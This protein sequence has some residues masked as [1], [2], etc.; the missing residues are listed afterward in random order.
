MFVQMKNLKSLVEDPIGGHF[1]SQI[2]QEVNERCAEKGEENDREDGLRFKEMVSLG[3]RQKI[4]KKKCVKTSI[5]TLVSFGKK[6]IYNIKGSSADKRSLNWRKATFVEGYQ[7]CN[8]CYIEKADPRCGHSKHLKGN[9]VGGHVWNPTLKKKDRSLYYYILPICRRHNQRSTYDEPKGKSDWMQTTSDAK[10]MRIRSSSKVPKWKGSKLNTFQSLAMFEETDGDAGECHE[11]TQPEQLTKWLLEEVHKIALEFAKDTINAVFK[12][13]SE[14]VFGKL[15][16]IIQSAG[17]D[18]KNWAKSEGY[19]IML[20]SLIPIYG[21][22]QAIK[23]LW[24]LKSDAIGR[25]HSETQSALAN[26][27]NE[28]LGDVEQARRKQRLSE[29]TDKVL[30]S[31]KWKDRVVAFE[32]T[33]ASKVS[34]VIKLEKNN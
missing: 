27:K 10:A 26:Y 13:V 32:K 30:S 33:I 17:N 5:G 14:I 3:L 7:E 8:K 29:E 2:L 25:F 1:V 23:R 16:G 9:I 20:Q 31:K 21:I 11:I 19:D 4:K 12:E 24:D 18:A 34:T 22:Y 15:K 28:C 6:I